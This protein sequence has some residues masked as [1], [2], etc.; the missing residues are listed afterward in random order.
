MRFRYYPKNA[1]HTLRGGSG[2]LEPVARRA[3]G[4]TVAAAWDMV[5]G[6]ETGLLDIFVRGT[7]CFNWLLVH[8]P[9]SVRRGADAVTA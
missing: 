8:I 1:S 3:Q 5:D 7:L 4:Q 9:Y 2:T 6:V